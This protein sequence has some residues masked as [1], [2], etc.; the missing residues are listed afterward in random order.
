MSSAHLI[1]K[2]LAF[3]VDCVRVVER[4]LDDLLALVRCIRDRKRS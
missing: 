3:I 1:E 4:D 2:R